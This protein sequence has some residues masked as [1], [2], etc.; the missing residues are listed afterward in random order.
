MK[1]FDLAE[2]NLINDLQR[3]TANLAL[4]HTC[5][6]LC[7]LA[8]A[9]QSGTHV[10]HMLAGAPSVSAPPA[11]HTLHVVMRTPIIT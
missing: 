11:S 2:C 8:A 7:A 9:L 4:T 3:H 1:A 10:T 6:H 5:Q